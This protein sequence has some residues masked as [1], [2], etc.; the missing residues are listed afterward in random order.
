MET[1]VLAAVSACSGALPFLVA[2]VSLTWYRSKRNTEVLDEHKERVDKM[3]VKLDDVEGEVKTYTSITETHMATIADLRGEIRDNTMAVNRIY[4][5]L[6]N[7]G[8][9]PPLSE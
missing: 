2:G 5:K 3:E 8:R 1:W 6:F 9:R 7:G 4:G